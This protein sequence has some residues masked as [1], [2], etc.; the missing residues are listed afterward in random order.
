M[1]GPRILP[2]T[3]GSIHEDGALKEHI[4]T[5]VLFLQPSCT[6]DGESRITGDRTGSHYGAES[7]SR[8]RARSAF[9]EAGKTA[10][11]QEKRR[12]FSN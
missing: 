8:L 12:N 2:N 11:G 5:G 7:Q 1:D 6:T 3:Q 10:P 4:G 9:S